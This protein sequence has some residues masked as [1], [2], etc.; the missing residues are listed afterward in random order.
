MVHVKKI[1]KEKKYDYCA[2]EIQLLTLHLPMTDKEQSNIM[3]SIYIAC[4]R[5][6]SVFA[7]VI[8]LLS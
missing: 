6:E 4:L 2:I 5:V 8:M 7:C 1:K 3:Y